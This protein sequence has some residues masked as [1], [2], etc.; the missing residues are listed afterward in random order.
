MQWRSIALAGAFVLV[1]A[2][3]FA[4]D[5]MANTYG[6][7]VHTT[8]KATGV[9][10]TLLFDQNNTYTANTTDKDGKPV[11]YQGTWALQDGGKTICLTPN[12]PNANPPPQT[13]CSPLEKHNVGDSWT[14]TNSAGD[15]FDV[16]ITA[17]R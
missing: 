16:S 2:S 8:N 17:G 12:I 4:D 11:T 14:V 6:N 15:T 7:T 3:A 13:T 5:P 1:S 10:G 9:Q